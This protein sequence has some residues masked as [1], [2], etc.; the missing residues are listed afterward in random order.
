M[1]YQRGSALT[2]AG[3]STLCTNALPIA[4][5]TIVLHEPVPAGALGVLRVFAFAGV[6]AGAILLAH[7]D[8]QPGPRPQA[9]PVTYP[10]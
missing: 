6:V 8:P 10:G 2:V 9:Q 1:G 3:L 5:G 7:P 4:A